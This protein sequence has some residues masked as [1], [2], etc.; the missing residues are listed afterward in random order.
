MSAPIVTAKV[1]V[2]E[3]WMDINGHMNATHYGLVMYDGQVEFTRR[4]GLGDDYVAS[5]QCGKAVL[6][7]HITYEREVTTGDRI[8][9]WSWL[10]AV[11]RKR[12][13]FFHELFN[14]SKDCRAA[15][16]EK[17]D[18]HM[19]LRL[20]RAVPFP[21]VVYERLQTLVRENLAE[22]LPLG[23]GNQIRPP[24]NDWLTE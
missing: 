8:Q 7:N 5:T 1:T 10:L 17:I 11:D 23:I 18:V 22:S 13:H 9:V 19:D 14:L 20:R 2:P 4:L 12:V 3:K 21:D 6:A 16:S 15:T 24:V